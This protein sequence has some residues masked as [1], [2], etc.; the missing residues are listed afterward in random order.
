LKKQL[1]DLNKRLSELEVKV[2]DNETS[3]YQCRDI[4]DTNKLNIDDILQ[5]L[6]DL[7]QKLEG[8]EPSGPSTSVTN[9][10]NVLTIGGST[11]NVDIE[12]LMK[13]LDI[14]S[15]LKRLSDLEK[16]MKTKVDKNE[17]DNHNM[18]IREMIGNI[19]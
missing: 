16:E 7:S 14:D 9:K 13:K 1:A 15:L 4:T 17:F 5:K 10:T 11:T 3:I 8:V 18:S 2:K 12:G 19:H 6:F